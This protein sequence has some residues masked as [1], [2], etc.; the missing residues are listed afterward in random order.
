[1]QA[2]IVSSQ[3]DRTRGK[4]LGSGSLRWYCCDGTQ[5]SASQGTAA[6]VVSLWAESTTCLCGQRTCMQM[7]E[8]EATTHLKA[9][10]NLPGSGS[11][12]S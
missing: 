11:L 2:M 4:L 7:V 9:S 1:V 3:L 6:Q 5:L 12:H 10:V 8:H